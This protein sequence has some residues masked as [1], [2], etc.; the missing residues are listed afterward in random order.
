MEADAVRTQWGEAT[1]GLRRVKRRPNLM[2][3]GVATTIADRPQAEGEMVFRPYAEISTDPSSLFSEQTKPDYSKGMPSAQTPDDGSGTV[4]KVDRQMMRD[5]NRSVVLDL[6]RDGGPLSRSDLARRT[7]LSKPTVSEIVASLVRDELVHEVGKGVATA[8]GGRR[9]VLLEFNA[10]SQ[11]FVG[12]HFGVNTTTVAVAD[13]AGRTL[14][15]RSQTSVR[16]A[17]RRSLRAVAHMIDAACAAAEVP[18]SQL[19]SAAAAVP[20]L[21]DR[22]TGTCV[23]APNLGWRNVAVQKEIEDLLG[24]PA[25]AYNIA[26]AAAVAEGRI[27]AAK[28]ARSFVWVYVGTGVG[29]AVV[30]EGRLFYGV[31]GFS[32]EIGHCPVADDGP[33]CGCGRIGCLET[34]ASGAAIARSAHIALRGK[35]R[36]ILRH[37]LAPL[38]AED[39][40]LAAQEGDAVA[41]T[42]LAEAGEFLGRGISYL[43]N[44]LNPEMVVVGGR[45]SRAGDAWLEPVRASVR[46]HALDAELVPIV[47][48]V[49]AD[50]AEITGALLLAK[51]L[52]AQPYPVLGALATS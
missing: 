50:R 44:V 41:L 45:V 5:V 15:T 1:H 27:G 35:R 31:R 26:Q 42:V 7:S 12:I 3:E 2:T 52:A 29:A 19:R 21:V 33:V 17:P 40:A 16:G 25:G 30:S 46:H 36:T 51:D 28:G 39:V 23:V 37:I 48:S 18:R 20:G 11:A 43:V 38:T 22:T 49:L 24:V 6:I 9:P 32:G 14:A 34:V 47:V 8:I 10:S 13:G 4:R